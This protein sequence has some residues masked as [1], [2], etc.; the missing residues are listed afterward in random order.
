MTYEV[1]NAPWGGYTRQWQP[2]IYLAL[3]PRRPGL[4][5][6]LMISSIDDKE[7]ETQKVAQDHCVR[8]IMLVA[9]S[10]GSKNGF[11]DREYMQVMRFVVIVHRSLNRLVSFTLL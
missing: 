11:T 9:F 6:A 8:E 4:F 3:S 2:S 5:L 10:S 1:E 7:P